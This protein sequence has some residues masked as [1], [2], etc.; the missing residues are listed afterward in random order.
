MAAAG[1][2]IE[3]AKQSESFNLRVAALNCARHVF[4][5]YT[6]DLY[7]KDLL[8]VMNL[9]EGREAFFEREGNLFLVDLKM[10]THWVVKV[11]NLE[12]MLR[13]IDGQSDAGSVMHLG[14]H[15]TNLLKVSESI[16]VRR[17][18]G[19]S[20]LKIAS[21]MTYAQ[22]NELTVELF[23]GLEIGDPQISKYVPEFLGKMILKLPPREFDE[24]VKT[25]EGQLLT[26]NI[27]LAASMVQTVGIIWNNSTNLPKSSQK[28]RQSTKSA[29]AACCTS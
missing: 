18:A 19:N 12:L 25:I 24:F 7:Y 15:L 2:F 1:P 4:A 28:T 20:L 26:V 29:S 21:N 8:K 22:R 16:F 11:A 3:R 13:Y 27:P 6:D 23:N 14:T 17:A 10:G 9:P 5:D